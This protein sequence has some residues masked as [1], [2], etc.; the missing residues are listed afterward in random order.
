MREAG[1]ELYHGTI[2]QNLGSFCSQSW[3]DVLLTGVDL[4]N[5][6][7]NDECLNFQGFLE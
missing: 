4:R 5:D 7:S 6:Q 3:Q 2:D 1:S